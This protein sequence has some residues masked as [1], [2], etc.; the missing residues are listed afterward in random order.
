MKNN[1]FLIKIHLDTSN[2]V[3]KNVSIHR[4]NQSRH[5]MEHV[6]KDSRGR[7][8]QYFKKAGYFPQFYLVF[9]PADES[10]CPVV[11]GTATGTQ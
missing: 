8:I 3:S 10:D 11:T 7:S 5:V 4:H 1:N 9:L 6:S 2:D